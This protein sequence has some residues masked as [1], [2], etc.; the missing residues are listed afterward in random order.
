MLLK[1]KCKGWG[2]KVLISPINGKKYFPQKKYSSTFFDVDDIYGRRLLKA[3]PDTFEIFKPVKKEKV[4]ELNLTK[5]EQALNAYSY[6]EILN[7][8]KEK[9]L[10]TGYGKKKFQLIKEIVQKK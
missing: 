5:E 7:M 3:T 8:Y 4:V 6:D 10:G 1:V 9:G 2:D